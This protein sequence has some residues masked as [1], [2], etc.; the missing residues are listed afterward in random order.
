MNP[1]KLKRTVGLVAVGMI[2]L[3][4]VCSPSVQAEAPAVDPAAVQILKRMTELP[5][6]LE[7]VQR[8]NPEYH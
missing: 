6:S 2:T 7:T 4:A 3:W 5:G 8:E 1:L